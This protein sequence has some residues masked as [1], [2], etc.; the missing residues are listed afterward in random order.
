MAQSIIAGHSVNLTSKT[1]DG[2]TQTHRFISATVNPGSKP[3][4]VAGRLSNGQSLTAILS[5]SAE[6]TF[7]S[8]S[9]NPVPTRPTVEYPL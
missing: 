7:R 6:R 4:P 2:L 3:R 5:S 1:I 9:L 8:F